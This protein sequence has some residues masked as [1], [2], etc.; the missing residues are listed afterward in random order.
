MVLHIGASGSY[1]TPK[2]PELGDPVNSFRF[3]T[4][5]ETSINRKKY[6]D[7]DFI[8]NSKSGFFYNFELAFAKKNFKIG[9]EYL[10]G[11]IFRDTDKVPVGEDKPTLGGFFVYG[12]WIFNNADYYYNMGEAEF[13]QIN[14]RNNKKGAFEVALRYTYMN[15]NSF[16]DDEKTPYIPGGS[17][18]AYTIGLNYYFNF[19]V[20][21]MLDYSYVNHD[22]W[23]DGKG[24]YLTYDI[25]N[26]QD[27]TPTGKGGI[28]FHMLQAR[29]EIDF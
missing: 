10:K 28:D 29:I 23:A 14:F 17:G 19:N 7:T 16:K 5:A 20:K 26:G 13:S 18:E 6:I 21:I 1:R 4:R 3:S 9:G 8:E 25:R 24:K 15:A 22:R 2:I 27:V 12:G 11:K